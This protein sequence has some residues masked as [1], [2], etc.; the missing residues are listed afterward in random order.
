MLIV[1]ALCYLLSHIGAYTGFHKQWQK[2]CFQLLSPP[3]CNF[4]HCSSCLLY[5]SFQT[6]SSSLSFTFSSRLPP[7]KLAILWQSYILSLSLSHC[8]SNPFPAF[9]LRCH[10]LLLCPPTK[11]I[12]FHLTLGRQI[13]KKLSA[14]PACKSVTSHIYKQN[15]FALL[16]SLNSI[17]PSAVDCLALCTSCSTS[18]VIAHALAVW[19]EQVKCY[20]R[21]LVPG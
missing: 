11:I 13:F 2:T 15:N 6:L 9:D 14:A 3:L 4:S 16:T 1:M 7:S 18:L 20:L 17:F 5:P 12:S 8:T 10:R 19:S 21:W